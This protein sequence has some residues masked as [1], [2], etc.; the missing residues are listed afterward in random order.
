MFHGVWDGFEDGAAFVRY[1]MN[2]FLELEFR[3]K[4]EM[5]R[6][7]DPGS[8]PFLWSR[9]TRARHRD[10]S[11]SVDITRTSWSG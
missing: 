7:S 6:L 9:T 3:Y 8:G 2:G 5:E 1:S 4:I 11:Q 10:R